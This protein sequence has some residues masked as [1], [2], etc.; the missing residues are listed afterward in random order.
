MTEGDAFALLAQW[1]AKYHM[2]SITWND[3]RANYT[4]P[5]DYLGMV[6]HEEEPDPEA[7][8]W[9][10][11]VEIHIYPRTPVGQLYAYGR[12]LVDAVE[13]MARGFE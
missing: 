1:S 7:A 6:N 10:T 2:V 13:S 3:H 12:T 5:Q 8:D 4:T 9:D 11:L